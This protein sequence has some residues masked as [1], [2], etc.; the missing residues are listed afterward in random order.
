M[1]DKAVDL[2]TVPCLGQMLLHEDTLLD[3]VLVTEMYEKAWEATRNGDYGVRLMVNGNPQIQSPS[4]EERYMLVEFRSMTD[5]HIF[6][7]WLSRPE[8]V[9]VRIINDFLFILNTICSLNNFFLFLQ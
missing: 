7:K 5:G 8:A 3:G 9:K 2:S 6:S 1:N 4:K